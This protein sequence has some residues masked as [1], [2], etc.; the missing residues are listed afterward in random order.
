MDEL[1]RVLFEVNAPD[2]HAA[3]PDVDESVAAHRQVVLADL[4]TLRQVWIHV[5]LAVELGVARDLAAEGQR[6]LEARL[7]RRLVDDRQHTGHAEA[8]LTDVGV[9]RITQLADGTTAEH[10]RTRGRLDMHLHTDHHLPLAQSGAT[11][12]LM[13]LAT[14]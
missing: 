3:L 12:A 14:S 7:D 8:D 11:S 10:L 6:G 4:V 13:P 2:A 1:A 5:V 9:R